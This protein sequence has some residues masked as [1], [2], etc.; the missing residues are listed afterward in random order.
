MKRSSIYP[1]T[2]GIHYELLY[3]VFCESVSSKFYYFYSF[4]ALINFAVITEKLAG[5]I[6][7]PYGMPTVELIGIADEFV[8]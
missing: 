3:I 4:I 2:P 5:D 7:S 6:G 1:K 8:K